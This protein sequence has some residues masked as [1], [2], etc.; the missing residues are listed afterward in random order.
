MPP[1]IPLLNNT[2]ILSPDEVAAFKPYSWYASTVA[3]N[4]D[5]IKTWSCGEKCAANPDFEYVITG[6]YG[7][8]T[9]FCMHMCFKIFCLS[10]V[11]R[12]SYNAGF[13]GY[14]PHLNEVIVSHQGTD[15]L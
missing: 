15:G 2:R 12:F 14:D 7:L 13:S 10:L 11:H 9:Q 5:D 4:I 6:Q 8:L 1:V 3:C